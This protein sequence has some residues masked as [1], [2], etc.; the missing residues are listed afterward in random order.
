MKCP[1]MS[2][3]V[4]Q[5]VTDQPVITSRP[6]IVLAVSCCY[7]ITIDTRFL[8][9]LV[10]VILQTRPSQNVTMST[11]DQDS[12]TWTSKTPFSFTLS[13]R[14]KSAMVLWSSHSFTDFVFRL[15]V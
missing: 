6:L 8:H 15:I 5:V 4:G 12:R 10:L 7:M 2:A 3:M 11:T 1:G 14:H 13:V 9:L